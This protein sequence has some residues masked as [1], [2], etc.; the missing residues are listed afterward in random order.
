MGRD[1]HAHLRPSL[2]RIALSGPRALADE[3]AKRKLIKFEDLSGRYDF[4]L[5]AVE[6]LATK[7]KSARELTDTQA[8]MTFEASH[9]SRAHS[10]SYRQIA[11]AVLAG[12]ARDIFEAHSCL[13]LT[14]PDFWFTHSHFIYHFIV[15]LISIRLKHTNI[16]EIGVVENNEYLIHDLRQII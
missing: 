13:S 8:H 6:T 9:D 1:S 16:Y 3:K 12:N 14:A 10:P 2:L 4:R 5:C 11:V 15:L 7:S